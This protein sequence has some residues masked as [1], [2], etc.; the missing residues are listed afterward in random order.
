M[1]EMPVYVKI[2]MPVEIKQ[3]IDLLRQYIYEA[4][5]MLSKIDSL[6]TEESA[7][8]SQW[9]SNFEFANKIIDNITSSLG[10]PE[11]I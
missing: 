8:I 3:N 11:K 5:E 6:S 4:R 9:N 10:E 1:E 2:D 7:K